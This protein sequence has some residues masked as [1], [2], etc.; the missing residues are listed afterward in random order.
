MNKYEEMLKGYNTELSDESV[1]SAVK[2]ILSNNMEA[3]KDKEVYKLLFNCIDL[4]S[5]NTTDTT[6][7]IANFTKKVNEFEAEYPQYQT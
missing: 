1:K 5:L 2:E 3:A 7:H 6:E 4:T